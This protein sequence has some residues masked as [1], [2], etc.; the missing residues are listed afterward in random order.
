MYTLTFSKTAQ[1][2]GARPLRKAPVQITTRIRDALDRLA[3]NPDAPTLM[4]SPYRACRAS[5]YR[6]AGIA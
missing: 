3:E 2:P 4:L 1:G 5:G 6:L